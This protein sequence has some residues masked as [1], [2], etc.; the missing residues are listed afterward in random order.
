MKKICVLALL[1]QGT[2][3]AQNAIPYTPVNANRIPIGAFPFLNLSYDARSAA[4]GEAGVATTPDQHSAYL[5]PAKLVFLPKKDSINHDVSAL[6]LAFTKYA[7][8]LIPGMILGGFS[9]FRTNEKNQAFALNVK[10]FHAGMTELRD[11]QGKFVKNI[12]SQEFAIEGFHARPINEK[13]S[14]AL[15]LRLTHSNLAQNGT[16]NVP[17]KPINAISGDIFYFHQGRENREKQWLN[18]GASLTNIGAKVAYLDYKERSFQPTRLKVGIAQNFILG[19]TQKEKETRL[20]LTV[21]ANKLLVPTQPLRAIDNSILAGKDEATISGIGSIFQ[22]WTT[23][24]DGI[25]ETFQEIYYN[26]GAELDIKE[27]IALRAGYFAQNK[28]KGNLHYLTAG[29]G[30]HLGD[31]SLDAAL[32]FPDKASKLLAQTFRL[33]LTYFPTKNN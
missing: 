10:Y 6:S 13:N 24:P 19:S 30:L 32:L 11:F 3:Y 31:F 5:N 7:K 15:G 8:P 23:A 29:A 25:K 20:M 12:R 1:L 22:S 9:A 27:F 14:F 26:V 2:L 21:D 28:N 16:I 4:I 33:Q 17:S 18:Y